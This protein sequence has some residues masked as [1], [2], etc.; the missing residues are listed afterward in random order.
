MRTFLTFNDKAQFHEPQH[1]P[2]DQSAEKCTTIENFEGRSNH[3]QQQCATGLIVLHQTVHLLDEISPSDGGED[4]GRLI[5]LA[6]QARTRDAL[7][8]GAAHD[9]GDRGWP[10]RP[11]RPGRA[12]RRPHTRRRRRQCRC[13]SSWW[14][15]LADIALASSTRTTSPKRRRRSSRSTAESRS[16]AASSISKSAAL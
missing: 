7:P 2:A 16:S 5:A 12:G 13:A 9:R 4:V 1:K 6:T 10:G 3:Q 11:G 15:M 8:L 14:R